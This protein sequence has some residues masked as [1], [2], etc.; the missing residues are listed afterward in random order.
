MRRDR[1]RRTE[2][3]KRKKK[4]FHCVCEEKINNL[5]FLFHPALKQARLGLKAKQNELAELKQL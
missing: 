3:N 1:I 4:K 2:N 5:K